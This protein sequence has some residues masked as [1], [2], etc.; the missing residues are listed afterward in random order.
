MPKMKTHKASK[1]RFR[2]TATGKLKRHKAGKKHLLSHKTG[3]RKRQLRAVVIET[4]IV[5][6]KYIRMMGGRRRNGSD[7]DTRSQRQD[8]PPEPQ[9]DPQAHQG[10]SRW[11]APPVPAMLVTLIRGRVYAFR[12]RRV[13]KRQFRRLWIVRINAA[14]RMRGLRY[15][16]LIAGLQHANVAL[17]RKTL[18]DLAVHEP[19]VVHQDRRAGA[20]E[21]AQGRGVT[22]TSVRPS[23]FSRRPLGG[24]LERRP[25]GGG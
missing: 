13:K 11:P 25:E 6:K 9:T 21:P 1:K 5:A 16:E 18:A 19:D 24:V 4:G 2:V 7:H 15:S 3:K 10:L 23:S 17:D 20:G 12:D 14:C 8:G 22:I